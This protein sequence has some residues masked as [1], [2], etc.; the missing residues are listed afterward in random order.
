MLV[1]IKVDVADYD[2]TRLS[3]A[4]IFHFL[5]QLDQDLLCKP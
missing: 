4:S 2:S 3:G 5:I 1:E